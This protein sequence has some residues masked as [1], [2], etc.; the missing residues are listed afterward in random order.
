M[1]FVIPG[2]LPGLNEIIGANRGNRYAG[3]SQKKKETRRCAFEIIRQCS[4]KFVTPIGISFTWI[5]DSYKRD[6]DNICAGQKF[7]LD[8]LVECGRLENDT[9]KYV[10]EIRHHFAMPDKQQPRIEV[11]ITV[12]NESPSE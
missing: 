3:A 11:E 6:P 7:I 2:R 9:R 12:F 1:K 8:A 4:G 5:E 10:K